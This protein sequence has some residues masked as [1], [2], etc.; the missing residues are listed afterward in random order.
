[1]VSPRPPRA[2]GVSDGGPI[3]GRRT[4]RAPDGGELVRRLSEDPLLAALAGP[5]PGALVDRA[6]VLLYT[7]DDPIGDLP[8]PGPALFLVVAGRIS[9]RLPGTPAGQTLALRPLDANVEAWSPEELVRV[10]SLL[11]EHVGPV[12]EFL[13]PR[14][15]ALTADPGRLRR[16]LAQEIPDPEGRARFLAGAPQIPTKE[17]GVGGLFGV[18]G[19]F[20][21]GNPRLGRYIASSE[22][23][24]LR[25]PKSTVY[26]ALAAHPDRIEPTLAAIERWRSTHP[27][28]MSAGLPAVQELR[29]Q[30]SG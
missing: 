2:R 18:D 23:A 29:T 8:D 14:A 12:A 7:E 22:G 4:T 17:I 21:D 1:M 28:E 25:L 9:A 13:V 6:K 24:L 3:R 30:L 16:I 19:V 5:D 15:A 20:G 27:N 26:A 11:I 10:E